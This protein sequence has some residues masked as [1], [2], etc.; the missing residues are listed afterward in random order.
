MGRKKKREAKPY[1]WYCGPEREFEDETTLIQHQVG[2]LLEKVVC[3]LPIVCSLGQAVGEE[4]RT[5]T[6]ATMALCTIS[7]LR[8]HNLVV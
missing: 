4:R 7:S 3:C 6:M 1:C 8:Q 5:C 2:I